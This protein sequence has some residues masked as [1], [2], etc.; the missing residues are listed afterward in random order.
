[1]KKPLHIQI[2][3]LLSGAYGKSV[4]IE[5]TESHECVWVGHG[6]LTVNQAEEVK[7]YLSTQT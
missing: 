7:R 5:L 1:M 3:R 4:K 6:K 2:R